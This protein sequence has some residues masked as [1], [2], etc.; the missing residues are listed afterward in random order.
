MG[1][2]A[3]LMKGGATL[4]ADI[5][6]TAMMHILIEG[7]G[8][9]DDQ[10]GVTDVVKGGD[11]ED[12]IVDGQDTHQAQAIED[13]LGERQLAAD[14]IECGN[15][16][17]QHGPYGYQE[18]TEMQG[19]GKGI[20]RGMIVVMAPGALRE[21]PGLQFFHCREHGR[22]RLQVCLPESRPAPGSGAS[23]DEVHS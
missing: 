18:Q 11:A 19:H 21:I 9:I 22:H 13:G 6:G 15:G 3:L 20:E 8:D 4:A 23:K 5:D 16:D 14:I 10:Q 7:E 12:D 1:T 17:K 2:L